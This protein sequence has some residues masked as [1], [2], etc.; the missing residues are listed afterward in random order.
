M[1]K[2]KWQKLENGLAIPELTFQTTFT[3]THHL[4]YISVT[5]DVASTVSSRIIQF[6][7]LLTVFEL[8]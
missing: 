1:N 7:A 6:C 2:N 3:N 8:V 5:D 4:L